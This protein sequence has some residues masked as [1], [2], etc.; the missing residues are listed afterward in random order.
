ME[1]CSRVCLPVV[2]RLLGLTLRP[3]APVCSC[4]RDSLTCWRLALAKNTTTGLVIHCKERMY[5]VDSDASWHMMGPSSLNHNE[6]EAIRLSRKVLIF[7]PPTAF[8]SRTRKQRSAQRRLALICGYLQC[9]SRHQCCRC[10]DFAMNL[11]VLVR[12]G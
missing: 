5:T 4:H 8:L 2:S 1:S 9:K 12:G 10:E 7:S 3:S 6:N 11:V